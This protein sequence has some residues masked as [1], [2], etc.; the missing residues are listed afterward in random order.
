M[1]KDIWHV[2]ESALTPIFG[3]CLGLQSLAIE[4]GGRT[5]WGVTA[6]IL[7]ILYERLYG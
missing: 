4:H 1:V 3:V 5:I 7:R 2:E 6:G